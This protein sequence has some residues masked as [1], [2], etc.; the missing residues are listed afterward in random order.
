MVLVFVLVMVVMMVTAAAHAIFVVVM[1]MMLV[2]VLLILAGMGGVGLGGQ[3]QQTGGKVLPLRHG[4]EDL[5]AG[6]ILPGCGDD[7]GG[8]VLFPQQGHRSGHLVG[9]GAA[10]AA[11]QD[12]A[13]VLD[14]VVVELAKVLHIQLDLVDV[15]HRHKA[16]QLHVQRLGHCLHRPGDVGQLAHARGFDEDAVGVVLLH[17]LAQRLPEIAHQRAADAPGVQLIDLDAGF[18]QE[19]AVNADLAKLVFDQHHLLSLEGLADQ[20]LDQGGLASAQEAGENIDLGCHLSIAS[21]SFCRAQRGALPH[22]SIHLY[23]NKPV[24]ARIQKKAGVCIL[25]G[26]MLQ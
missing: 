7:G 15:G 10:G 24:N 22:C 26:G 8:G 18:L 11:E 20:L 16:G 23:Y 14:L 4:L 19:A 13:G 25:S 5:R 3:G 2:L 12:A 21:F 1:V 17:H 9:V 6:Q